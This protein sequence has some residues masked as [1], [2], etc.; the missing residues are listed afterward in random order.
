[1]GAP[2]QG[3]TG[4]VEALEAS[5]ETKFRHLIFALRRMHPIDL[6]LVA[7]ELSRLEWI[8]DDYPLED[9]DGDPYYGPQGR[10]HAATEVPMGA[11]ALNR[12][13]RPRRGHAEGHAG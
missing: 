13:D 9:E 7:T 8:L 11:S 2:P 4:W 5:A 6:G 12:R 10:E 1:M 3:D